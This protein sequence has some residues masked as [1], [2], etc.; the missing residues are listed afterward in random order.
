MRKKL[1]SIW[2]LF[3]GMLLIGLCVGAQGTLISLRAAL[4][5]FPNTLTGLIMSAYYLGFLLGAH[6]GQKVIKR[7][8]HVRTFGALTALSSL[9]VLLHSLYINPWAWFATRFLTGFAMCGIYLVAESWLNQAADDS[10]RGKIMSLYMIT[11]LGGILGGQFLLNLADP[12]SFELFSLISILM[13]AAAIPI[14]ATATPTPVV[15]PTPSISPLKLFQW[16][17][18]GLMG[19]FLIQMCSAMVFGMAPVYANM[20]GLGT[21]Q[22]AWLMAAIV[23]GAL[24]LQWPLGMLADRFNR[25]LVAT[26]LTAIAGAL[27]L[28][29]S[30]LPTENFILLLVSVGIFG[31]FALPLYAVFS[32]LVNDYMRPEKIVAASSTILLVGGVGASVGPLVVAPFLDAVGPRGFFWSC[33]ISLFTISLYGLYRMARFPYSA[34]Q[35]VHGMSAQSV[36]T[37]GTG[38]VPPAA[39]KTET[40]A[41]IN[42]DDF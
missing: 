23:A 38:L 6:R 29:A 34:R 5:G 17:P 21:H 12:R 22:V 24:V 37:V 7:V 36:G 30:L 4:E 15:T 19:V 1:T 32:A 42:R 8:G 13:S 3:F 9:C 27:A 16:A 41:D 2:P 40:K 20:V 11:L 28:T 39:V 26:T 25:R 14:L 31:G 18:F 35:D 33:A 10:N